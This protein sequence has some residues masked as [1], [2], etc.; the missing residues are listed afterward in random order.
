MTSWVM[1]VEVTPSELVAVDIDRTDRTAGSASLRPRRIPWCP[2][3]TGPVRRTWT[4]GPTRS[5]SSP[6]PSRAP[7]RAPSPVTVGAGERRPPG[8][9]RG[10][11]PARHRAPPLRGDRRG[12]G[13]RRP[14]CARLAA[15]AGR[16]GR[17]PDRRRGRGRRAER[18][19]G[20]PRRRAHHLAGAAHRRGARRSAPAGRSRPAP[21]ST[22]S[23]SASCARSCTPCD[24]DRR[25]GLR[26]TAR[27][28]SRTPG[29]R[30]LRG[31]AARLRRGIRRA[32]AAA[33]RRGGRRGPGGGRGPRGRGGPRRLRPARRARP[34]RDPRRGRGRT[35]GAPRPR[36][37]RPRRPRDPARLAGSPS[38]PPGAERAEG[39]L[40]LST[41]RPH[42]GVLGLAALLLPV[43]SRPARAA[44]GAQAIRSAR[45]I[46]SPSAPV[47][48]GVSGLVGAGVRR[49]GWWPRGPA[50]SRRAAGVPTVTVLTV[51]TTAGLPHPGDGL[52]A[53][54]RGRRRVH[55]RGPA[56]LHPGPGAAPGRDARRLRRC[57]GRPRGR[58]RSRGLVGSR[59]GAAERPPGP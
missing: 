29:A 58:H 40:V 26:A 12:D 51:P 46:G 53:P 11:D 39:A 4:P 35:R 1:A 49:V 57:P 37:P 30:D 44:S 48:A 55:P 50:R 10:R 42:D 45:A 38:S 25:G 52:V 33:R 31:E 41:G 21:G 6:T 54:R 43:R 17:R 24:P 20:R 19:P 32:R 59:L 15:R 47:P 23:C 2:S 18:R 16:A 5:T 22:S 56:A 3:P 28:G 34:A 13:P 36:R 27:A 8:P 14:A 9:A 7:S